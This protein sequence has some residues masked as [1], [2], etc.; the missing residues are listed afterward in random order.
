MNQPNT[1]PKS[2]AKRL[3]NNALK[4]LQIKQRQGYVEWAHVHLVFTELLAHPE[5][6]NTTTT[7][8]KTKRK[9]AA[10]KST[11]DYNPIIIGLF[12]AALLLIYLASGS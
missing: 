11:G 7:K 5:F 10:K 12:L 3:V 4:Q 9:R 8:K 2:T 1:I 6:K